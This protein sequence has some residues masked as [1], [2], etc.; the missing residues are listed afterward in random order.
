MSGGQCQLH[1]VLVK[2]G[3]Q[4]DTLSHAGN[5]TKYQDSSNKE[6]GKRIDIEEVI[7]THSLLSL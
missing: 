2:E 4:L 6:G 3:S 1:E 5:K 7:P